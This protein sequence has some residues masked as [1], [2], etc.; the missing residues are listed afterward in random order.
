MRA[1]NRT[2]AGVV[3]ACLVLAVGSVRA[4]A[5]E[6]QPDR[7]PD[8]KQVERDK[9]E[10]NDSRG[11]LAGPNVQEQSLEANRG[12]G[13]GDR[14]RRE[15]TVPAN[16]WFRLVNAMSLSEE[17]RKSIQKLTSE[18]DEAVRE[19]RRANANSFRELESKIAAMRSGDAAPDRSVAQQLQ[20][21]RNG[22][23]KIEQLQEKIWSVLSEVQQSLMREQLA[24]ARARIEERAEQRRAAA[25]Q[26]D[27][28]PEAPGAT[29]SDQMMQE[30]GDRMTSG[31]LPER[32]MPGEMRGPGL[33]ERSL[34]RLR[35]LRQHQRE[36]QS[37]MTNDRA[38]ASPARNRARRA[39]ARPDEDR[40]GDN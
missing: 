6:T 32:A 40:T 37:E 14:A 20:Q 21:L 22:A 25:M 24:E 23:P 35:F 15:V 26:S 7:K 16:A 8:Q 30:S 12:F 29:M 38:P 17:Q 31:G 19:Y 3:M 2:S 11:I 5:Q 4:V 27:R 13:E 10:A 9:K 33:D 36:Q 18:H 39:N 1:M 28:N 34:R